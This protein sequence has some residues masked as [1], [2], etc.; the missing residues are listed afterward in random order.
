MKVGGIK[1][2]YIQPFLNHLGRQRYRIRRAGQKY[3]E[4]H[5]DPIREP[6]QFLDEY[7][8][9]MRAPTM[10]AIIQEQIKTGG[11]GSINDALDRYM[12]SDKWVKLAPSTHSLRR[13]IYNR[14]RKACGT[15]LLSDFDTQYVNDWLAKASAAG[16]PSTKGTLFLALKPFLTWA[17]EDEKLIAVN[18]IAGTKIVRH[19]T[20]G[21]A[22]WEA[23]EIAR[24]RDRHPLGTMERVAIELALNICGRRSDV[25][26]LGPQHIKVIDGRRWLYFRQKKNELRKPIDVKVPVLPALQAAIDACKIVSTTTFVATERGKPFSSSLFGTWFAKAC[27]DAGLPDHCVTHGLRKSG[28]VMLA[29]AGASDLE[30][31]AVGGWTTLKEVQRYTKGARKEVLAGNAIDKL[32]AYGIGGA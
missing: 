21:H 28:A 2:K 12:L 18:P 3:I 31:M 22:T 19:E 26:K 14:L 4:L 13:P 25:I 7:F 5:R 30:I 1:V 27:D 17:V 9:A 16:G 20:D 8:A 29:Y 10:S 11:V 24:Y 32:L 6:L 23:D 15:T